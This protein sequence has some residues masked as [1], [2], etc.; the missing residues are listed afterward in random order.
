MDWKFGTS[1]FLLEDAVERFEQNGF[2]A[3]GQLGEFGV[4]LERA[5]EIEF[6]VFEIIDTVHLRQST[7]DSKGNATKMGDAIADF[8]VAGE[9]RNDVV[10]IPVGGGFV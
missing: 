9:I 10:R 1:V 3:G 8:D 4:G 2:E 5:V 7:G 6:L